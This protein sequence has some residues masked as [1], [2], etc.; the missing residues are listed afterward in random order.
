MVS[1]ALVP[2]SSHC[3]FVSAQVIRPGTGVRSGGFAAG[4]FLKAPNSTGCESRRLAVLWLPCF[5]SVFPCR[6]MR[7]TFAM[8]EHSCE[9][10]SVQRDVK[11]SRRG[12]GGC[13]VRL[14]GLYARVWKPAVK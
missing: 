12:S 8:P 2:F 7:M 13:V 10:C 14:A 5:V 6:S 4:A 1:F 11:S 3:R 9:A